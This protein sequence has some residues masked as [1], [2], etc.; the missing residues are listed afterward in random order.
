MNWTSL[1]VCRQ[2]SK[3]I[4]IMEW[5]GWATDGWIYCIPHLNLVMK[6]L[7]EESDKEEAKRK[8]Q[9]VR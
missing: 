3:K 1:D 9:S 8:K 7:K 2:C 5:R 6:R 4:E